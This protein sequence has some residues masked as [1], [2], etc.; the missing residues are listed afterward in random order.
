MSLLTCWFL[1]LGECSM[2]LLY[3]LGICSR[4]LC[5]Y[6]DETEYLRLFMHFSGL[7]QPGGQIARKVRQTSNNC[8]YRGC[9]GQY[10]DLPAR[11]YLQIRGKR[12][13]RKAQS[14]KNGWNVRKGFLYAQIIP[15]WC[16][17]NNRGCYISQNHHILEFTTGKNR[18]NVIK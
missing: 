3:R 9:G 1:F 2:D 10:S 5:L 16:F 11:N 6:P 17:W 15:G 12:W 14:R 13:L 7:F 18:Q 8:S 4:Q